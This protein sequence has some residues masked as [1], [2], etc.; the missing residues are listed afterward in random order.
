MREIEIKADGEIAGLGICWHTGHHWPPWRLAGGRQGGAPDALLALPCKYFP[1][2]PC[3][4]T[5]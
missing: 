2:L 5:R 1:T 3:L 4:P